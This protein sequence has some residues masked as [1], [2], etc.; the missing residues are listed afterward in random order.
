MDTGHNKVLGAEGESL[1][2]SYLAEKG[3]AIL[4]KNFYAGR[5]GEIDL[6]ALK[7]RLLLFIEVKTRST[8]R[9]GGGLYSISLSKKKKLRAS[10]KYFLVK[11]PQYDS[12]EYTMR[13]DLVIVKNGNIQYIEDIIR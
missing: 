9:F 5:A 8:D 10:A 1:A 2:C 7:E 6:V 13:F 12:S 11:H 3:F 4:E